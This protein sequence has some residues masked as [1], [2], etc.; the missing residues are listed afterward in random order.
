MTYGRACYRRLV[1]GDCMVPRKPLAVNA[2]L[3]NSFSTFNFALYP[4]KNEKQRKN[5]EKRGE[6][7]QRKN[8]NNDQKVKAAQ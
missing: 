8:T 7:Q 5:T 1:L 3:V 6:F 2:Q 4:A